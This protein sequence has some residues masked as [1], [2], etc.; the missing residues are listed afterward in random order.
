M[1]IQIK[2]RTSSQSDQLKAL[3]TSQLAIQGID[4]FSGSLHTP[5]GLAVLTS[6]YG[7]VLVN[8]RTCTMS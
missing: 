7:C 1:L 5:P 3:Q 4:L 6:F 8:C 2:N